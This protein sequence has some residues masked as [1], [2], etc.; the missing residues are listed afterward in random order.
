MIEKGVFW[1][2]TF[3]KD[4]AFIAE[5]RVV[6]DF[7]KKQLALVCKE[8]YRQDKKH[9]TTK[10]YFCCTSCRQEYGELYEG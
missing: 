6:C 8:E 3:H 1:E 5:Y 4:P 2:L 7:C 10:K 9:L